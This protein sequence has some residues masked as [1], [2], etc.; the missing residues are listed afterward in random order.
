MEFKIPKKL[1]NIYIYFV[2]GDKCIVFK[3]QFIFHFFFNNLKA[4]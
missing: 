4:L 3:I 2:D 1:L